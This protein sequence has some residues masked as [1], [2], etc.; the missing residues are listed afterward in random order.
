LKT[1]FLS[2]LLALSL[3]GFSQNRIG[4]SIGSVR[5]E[6]ADPQYKLKFVKYDSSAYLV[7]EDK[8]ASVIHR[9]GSDSLCNK[10]YVTLPD[11]LIANQVASTYDAIYE[12]LSSLEWIVRLPDE[13]LN[14]EMVTTVNKE[15]LKQPTFE[16][17][18]KE[19]Q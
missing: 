19:K 4:K 6:Y 7:I 3:T 16:W 18:R 10:T 11:T 17:T 1:V 12:P 5:A 9:F 2:I 15:G 8:Y 14:V 13:V